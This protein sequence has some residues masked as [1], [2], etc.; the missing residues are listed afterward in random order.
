[1]TVLGRSEQPKPIGWEIMSAYSRVQL[2]RVREYTPGFKPI[3]KVPEA[4][5]PSTVTQ[6]TGT[7]KARPDD[8]VT[9]TWIWL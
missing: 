4:Q 2:V 3:L 6:F 5:Q 7:F 9:M 8:G 1:M